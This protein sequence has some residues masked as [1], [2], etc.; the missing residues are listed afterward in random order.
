MADENR[1]RIYIGVGAG[2]L[3][4][5]GIIFWLSWAIDKKSPPTKQ[6]LPPISFQV[7]PDI[8]KALEKLA[9]KTMAKTWDQAKPQLLALDKQN[10]AN[11]QYLADKIAAIDKQYAEAKERGEAKLTESLEA[12][13]KYYE[14]LLAKMNEGLV[15]Y[16]K[17]LLDAIAANKPPPPPPPVLTDPPPP[18]PPGSDNK[19]KQEMQEAVQQMLQS[20]AI[21]LCIA[22]PQ[23]CWIGALL[24][25]DLGIFGSTEEREEFLG[26]MRRF[27]TGQPVTDDDLKTLTNVF[28]NSNDPKAFDQYWEQI[29]RS[30]PP[31][32]QASADKIYAAYFAALD[33]K[34]RTN[35]DQIPVIKALRQKLEM[36]PAN[37]AD[38]LVA[39]PQ[40]GGK[41]F[42]QNQEEKRRA[43]VMCRANPEYRKYWDEALSMV[44]VK[45]Q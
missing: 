16:K 13:K 42:F 40:T 28:A 4:I 20:A 45:K 32:R 22:Q 3:L 43:E 23:F 9:D 8:E 37:A 19:A 41:A 7:G 27:A 44:E 38:V 36:K 33:A 11:H 1:N 6:Q 24:G 5:V 26:V 12:Q 25:I 21:A 18:P 31:E 10:A 35:E 29:R 30:L 14:D 39:L 15:K 2:L 17:D 34:N